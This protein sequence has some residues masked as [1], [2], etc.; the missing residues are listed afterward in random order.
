MVVQKSCAMTYARV[1][2]V[3]AARR[4]GSEETREG[5]ENARSTDATYDATTLRRYPIIL[6]YI[7]VLCTRYHT[8][9]PTVRS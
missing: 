1:Y 2:E 5:V 9:R 4:D 7:I 6:Y 8:V 3:H